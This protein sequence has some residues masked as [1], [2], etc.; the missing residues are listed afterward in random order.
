MNSEADAKTPRAAAPV[1]PDGWARAAVLDDDEAAIRV[2][3]TGGSIAILFLLAYLAYDLRGSG[4]KISAMAVYHWITVA[5]ALLFFG[6]TWTRGF[7]RYWKFWNLAFCVALVSIFVLI[8][9]QTREGDSRF[10]AALLF[11]IATASFVNWGWR[12]QAVTG[13]SCIA[14]YAIAEILAPLPGSGSFYRWL[15]LLAA[16]LLAQCTSLFIERYRERLRSQVHQL[17]EAAKFRETQVATMAHDIRGP[18]AAIAGFVDLLEDEDLADEDRQAVLARIGSTAWTM[19]LTV[20]NVLDLYQMQDGRIPTAPVLM[21]PNRAVAD[22]AS[23]C[24]AQ[25]VRQGLKLTVSYGEVRQGG[26]DPRH[27]ERI[28]RNMLAFC[29]ARLKSGEVTLTTGAREDTLVIEVEDDGPA[30]RPD[31][32][33]RLLQAPESATPSDLP[34]LGLY[35]AQALAQSSGG[36]FYAAAREG[37]GVR[38]VA[39]IPSARLAAA[40]GSA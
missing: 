11:P 6:L 20:S 36:R 23:I 35:V 37:G 24:A 19:D 40:A 8:S 26:F 18:V 17:V 38:L 25:A 33:G 7:R 14:L 39:E 12:W 10:I 16:A 1:A 15:G 31:E 3:R 28:A 32:L 27:L 5:A 13:L 4:G 22:A 9:A 21:D 34:A 29:I 2:L 30:L